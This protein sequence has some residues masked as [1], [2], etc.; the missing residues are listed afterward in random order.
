MDRGNRSYR[1]INATELLAMLGI[2]MPEAAPFSAPEW[3]QAYMGAH[4]AKPT[5]RAPL[6]RGWHQPKRNERKG[7][8]YRKMNMR[9][10]LGPKHFKKLGNN[11]AFIRVAA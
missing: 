5:T 1:R 6:T 8:C 10:E 4:L 9:G 7:P 11:A 2:K 3:L